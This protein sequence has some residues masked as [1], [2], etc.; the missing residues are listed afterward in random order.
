MGLFGGILGAAT[1][2]AAVI[3][4][5]GIGQVR[6]RGWSFDEPF[7]FTR[8]DNPFRYW[9]IVILF[10]GGAMVFLYCAVYPQ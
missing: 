7:V 2:F 6:L 9:A 4:W 8:A 10:A 1:F 3:Y 5:I